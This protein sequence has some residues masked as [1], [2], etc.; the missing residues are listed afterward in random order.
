MTS[1]LASISP[2]SRRDRWL[3][4]CL[5]ATA[6]V[7]GGVLLFLL[8][9]LLHEAWPVLRDVGI[10]PL[11]SD[12]SWHPTEERYNLLPMLIGTLYAALGALLIAVPLGWACAA[13]AVYYAPR[14][15]SAWYQNLVALA[16]G[17]PSVVYGLW[18]LVVLVP[19]IAAYQPPGASLIAAVLVLAVMIMPTIILLTESALR[20]VPRELLHGAA[21]LGLG[22]WAALRRVVV[23]AARSGLI[24]AVVLAAARALGETMAVL[25]VAGN[26]VQFPASVWEPMRT[27][28]ANI[29]LEMAYAMDHHRAALFASGLVLALLVTMIMLMAA[30]L[31]S[32][33]PT[34]ES[35]R[36][37]A[38]G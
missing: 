28:S 27:L 24:A 3:Q 1:W 11:L 2:P 33:L 14:R 6:L 35:G 5:R 36:G 30:R 20:S 29:A 9:F 21:A 31:H 7:A 12:A 32:P 13:Y 17:I 34:R 19:I 37:G 8:L 25:M 22:R 38:H 18:G 10:T 4:W 16:A 15:V 23:P 26:V